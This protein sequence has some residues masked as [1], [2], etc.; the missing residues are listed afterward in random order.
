MSQNCFRR[1]EQRARKI[2][3][4]P[5]AINGDSSLASLQA[6]HSDLICLPSLWL[7][8]LKE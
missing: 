2:N 4:G 7:A 1:A 8:F 3:F 5:D 6:H